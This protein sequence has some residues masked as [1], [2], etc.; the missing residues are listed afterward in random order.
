MEPKSTALYAEFVN[1]SIYYPSV[2]SELDGVPSTKLKELDAYEA[3]NDFKMGRSRE[4]L[5]L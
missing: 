2:N 3:I 4:A 1:K 5:Y